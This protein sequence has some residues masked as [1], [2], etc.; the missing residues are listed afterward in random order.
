M[1]TP[2]RMRIVLAD[3]H[4]LVREGV[5]LMLEKEGDL[6]VVGEAANG[7]EAVRLVREL[8][9]DVVVMDIAMPELN[10]LEA[11][12]EIHADA[13]QTRIVILSMHATAEHAARALRAGAGGYL[14]KESAGREVVAAVRA[15]QAG[16]RYLSQRIDE[17]LVE[18]QVP[19]EG[20]VPKHNPLETLSKRERE[21]LQLVAEGHSSAEIG[22]RLSLS[23]KTVD[24]Y[25]SRLMGKLGVRD[26]A[27]LIR[28]AIENG[29]TA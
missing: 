18:A 19:M 10:G 17:A 7:H 21:V 6:A 27:G 8:K 4:A 22:R 3:D 13:P 9:P 24:T 12:G 1:S 25:R 2:A 29:I 15:V 26:L 20:G 11:A 16:R 23:P 5:R 28:F 14:L